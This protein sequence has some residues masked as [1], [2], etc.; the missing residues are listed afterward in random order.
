PPDTG[1]PTFDYVF[2]MALYEPDEDDEDDAEFD[3]TGL[4]GDNS[5]VEGVTSGADSALW[6]PTDSN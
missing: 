4:D 2:W 1:P 5:I 3:L 6:R